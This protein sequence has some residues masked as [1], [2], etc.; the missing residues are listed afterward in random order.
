MNWFDRAFNDWQRLLEGL[1]TTVNGKP[2]PAT[3]EILN[4][5]DLLLK[6]APQIRTKRFLRSIQWLLPVLATAILGYVML[7]ACTH[8]SVGL[9]VTA[10]VVSFT[11]DGDSEAPVLR[12]LSLKRLVANPVTA[13]RTCNETS[14]PLASSSLD[15]EGGTLVLPTTQMRLNTFPVPARSRVTIGYPDRQQGLKVIFHYPRSVTIEVT[16]TS[17]APGGHS[18]DF[19]FQFQGTA[20]ELMIEPDASELAESVYGQIP[21]RAITFDMPRF[22]LGRSLSS[23]ETGTLSFTDIPGTKYTLD[24]GSRL[25]LDLRK[26]TL[27]DLRVARQEL[28]LLLQGDASKVRLGYGD[29]QREITPTKLDWLRSRAPNI[30]LWMGLIYFVA[31]LFGIGIPQFKGRG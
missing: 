14:S 22:E 10:N 24:R 4:N 2:N 18:C 30:E 25:L 29:D 15:H 8:N 7:V 13:F 17:A 28:S 11:L 3:L 12:E 19:A 31:I 6:T 20:M 9:A 26:G 5:I 1:P 27:A 23:I 21:I 16:G